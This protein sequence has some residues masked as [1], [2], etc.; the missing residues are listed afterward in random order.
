MRYKLILKES[1]IKELYFYHLAPK[2]LIETVGRMESL[3]YQYRNNKKA[4]KKNSAKYRN[5]LVSGWNVYP[6]RDPNSLTLDEVHDGIC[7]FRQSENGC[8]QIYLFRY[9]L[10]KDL[11]PNMSNTLIGKDIFQVK[12]S[13][14]LPLLNYV[15]WG[16]EGSFTGNKK[17]NKAYYI[18]VT[19]VQ[20]FS[21]YDDNVAMRFAALNHIS[22]SPKLAYIP[23]TYL[24]KIP[25]P[26]TIEDVVRYEI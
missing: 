13:L 2:G 10:F 21:K 15:D 9:P 11:G 14:I 16:W 23:S 22:I 17:L 8:N 7:K 20:Y 3:E 18:K 4:F 25:I 26:N 24:V 5:R 6:G 12:L 19:P 1:I